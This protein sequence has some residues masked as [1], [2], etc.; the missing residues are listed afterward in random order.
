MPILDVH[1]KPAECT[2]TPDDQGEKV[3]IGAEFVWIKVALGRHA[4][5]GL[6]A[7]CSSGKD[8]S[9]AGWWG[10][11]PFSLQATLPA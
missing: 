2:S 1:M 3:A 7:V 11:A 6:S 4:C 9:A 8:R 5:W 10:Y